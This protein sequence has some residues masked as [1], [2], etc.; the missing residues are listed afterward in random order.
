MAID[1]PD[2]FVEKMRQLLG[3]EFDAFM[4]SYEAPRVYG[5]R[6]NGLKLS[7]EEWQALSPIAEGAEPIPWAAEGLYYDEGHRPGKHPHYHAGLYYVQEPS[8]M[9]P[10]ELLDVQPGHRVLDLCAAPGGKSTQIAAKLQGSGVLVSNDNARE[11]TKALAKNIELAGVRNAIVLN[12]E[13]VKLAEVFD[14]W[15]DRILIDAPCSGEGMFRKDDSMIAQWEKHSVQKCSAMQRDILDHAASML[16]PG[17][18]LVYSTCTFSPEENEEQIARFLERNTDYRVV[19]IPL[20]QGWRAGKPEWASSLEPG[21]GRDS[22]AGTVRI[23]PHLVKGE[24]H[25]AAV[26]TRSGGESS[27]QSSKQSGPDLPPA[28]SKPHPQYELALRQLAEGTLPASAL[29]PERSKRP[30]N[31][32]DRGARMEER[33]RQAVLS[34]QQAVDPMRSWALFAERTIRGAVNWQGQYMSYGSRLYLQPGDVPPLDGLHVVRAGWYL[35]EVK[36]NRFDPSGALALGLRREEALRSLDLFSRDQ[37]TLKY[38]KGDT[39]FTHGTPWEEQGK[40]AKGHVLVCTDGYPIGWGKIDGA[41]V[42]NELPA[43]WRLL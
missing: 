18:I 26:L 35:G 38:L 6:V 36:P 4:A 7:A 23:W 15:F 30:D 12:D 28:A 40:P 29:Q 39:L 1:L 31:R 33:G 41:I 3:E 22:V 34:A 17:G 25:Y 43:G 37:D 20:R 8:A 9:A 13:P 27:K 42:K 10:V 16:A 11:R 2:R 21:E 24:G 5:L 32:R 19:P 14:D